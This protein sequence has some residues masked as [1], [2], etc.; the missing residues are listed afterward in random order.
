VNSA[1]T[2]IDRGIQDTSQI[3]N[4]AYIEADRLNQDASEFKEVMSK[5]KIA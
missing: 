5:F 4:Q 3:V 1:I 2:K